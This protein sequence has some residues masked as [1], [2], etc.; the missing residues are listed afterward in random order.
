M[1]NSKPVKMGGSIAAILKCRVRILAVLSVTIQIIVIIVISI[2]DNVNLMS[3]AFN[4]ESPS[5]MSKISVLAILIVLSIYD[6]VYFTKNKEIAMLRG[7]DED[8]LDLVKKVQSI[9]V[10]LLSVVILIA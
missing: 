8:F 1:P 2:L 4:I 7:Y 6:L 10:A 3:I 9:G 5:K